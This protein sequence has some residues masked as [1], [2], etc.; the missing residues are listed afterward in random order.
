MF[1]RGRKNRPDLTLIGLLI[2]VSIMSLLAALPFF[3]S[4]LAGDLLS[5]VAL[6]GLYDL[7]RL[8]AQTHRAGAS[9]GPPGLKL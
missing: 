5:M 9:C 4:S 7:A 8:R 6:F 2:V 1:S 3:C